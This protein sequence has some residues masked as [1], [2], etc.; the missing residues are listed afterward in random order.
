MTDT[1]KI[2]VMHNAPASRFEAQIPEG[3]CHA[4]YRR[5]GNALHMVHTET[6]P[7]ARGRGLA[8]LCVA[9]AL[10]YAEAQGLKVM[11]MCPYVRS[12]FRRHPDR[13]DLLAPGARL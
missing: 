5:V 7:E 13:Q 3:L 1:G 8:G 6:P 11:P 4:D 10:D 12:W 9:A 2:E